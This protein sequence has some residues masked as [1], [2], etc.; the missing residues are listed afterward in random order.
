MQIMFVIVVSVH[1]VQSSQVYPHHKIRMGEFD[2]ICCVTNP[3]AATETSLILMCAIDASF[4][5]L[6]SC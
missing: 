6:Q 4:A 1:Q 2:V 5:I 3:L